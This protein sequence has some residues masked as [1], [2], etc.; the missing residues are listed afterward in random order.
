MSTLD[1]CMDATGVRVLR[2]AIY[3]RV[4][5]DEQADGTSLDE[6]VNAG[7]AW[8][9]AQGAGAVLAGVYREDYTGT[10]DDR[11][12]WCRLLADVRAGLV[13][14][15]VFTKWDRWAR[16][17]FVGQKMRRD[18]APHRVRPVC[19]TLDVD[20]DTPEGDLMI[21]QMIGFAAY[22]KRNIVRRCAQGQHGTAALG[23]WPGGRPRFGYRAEGRKRQHV[24]V[25][26]FRDD[27]HGEADTLRRAWHLLVAERASYPQ[28]CAVLNAE[29]RT[30]RDGKGWTPNALRELL[31]APTMTGRFTWGGEEATGKWGPTK[32]LRYDPI[33]TDDEHAAL[34]AASGRVR[35]E[36]GTRRFYTLTG[37][38]LAPCGA[39]YQGVY[40]NDR[41]LRQYKCA[42][43]QWRPVG[44]TT[45]PCARLDAPDIEARV[46]T[47][48]TEFLSDSDRM[49][50]MAGDYLGLRDAQ[51]GVEHDELAAVRRHATTLE[52]AIT[53]TLVEYARQGIDPALTATATRTLRDELTA[54]REREAAILT[55]QA[56]SAAEAQR[57]QTI[58]DIAAGAR[59]RL[60]AMTDEERADVLR[61]L[62][63]TVTAHDNSKT[64]AL[65]I[66]GRL[67]WLDLHASL[68]GNVPEGE[69]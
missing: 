29:G 50:R 55:W 37:R 1:L 14:V 4:S 59:D 9:A 17:E 22:D 57:V 40:R 62:D 63:V 5:T 52:H 64:P 43:K 32:H 19:L 3:A 31:T 6:Q 27:G 42:N 68:A 65:T 58:S 13:D 21:G 15:I 12:E 35:V 11:P 8:I 2:V 53:T 49:L 24:L 69:L 48:V 60:H 67:A 16:D 10:T 23:Y 66:D 26:D 44:S 41:D 30:R 25:P 47:A 39:R 45:C 54:T 18:I 36:P 7:H 51:I 56:D 33:L 34:L 38:F 46:W 28:T 61:L 20:A